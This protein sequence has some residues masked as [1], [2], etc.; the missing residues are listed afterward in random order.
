M[1]ELVPKR[2]LEIAKKAR[3]L[4]ERF[5]KKNP[6]IGSE[7]LECYCAIGSKI[8][9]ELAK[10]EGYRVSFV[11][12]N[13]SNNKYTA[14]DRDIPNHCWVEYKKVILDITATQFGIQEKVYIVERENDKR[15]KVI[16]TGRKAFS[17]MKEWPQEQNPLCH[18]PTIDRL[19]K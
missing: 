15:Y 12:G 1:S 3:R 4:T 5:Q 7:D 16:S 13:F 11:E 2:L 6:E 19:T 9:Y 18:K 10:K 14:W 8:L 17:G